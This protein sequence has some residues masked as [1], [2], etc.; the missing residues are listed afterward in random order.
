MLF[1]DEQEI[2]DKEEQT[3]KAELTWLLES[4]LPQ[5]IKEAG[6]LLSECL[7]LSNA[8]DQGIFALSSTNCD[9]L[10]GYVT[11][12]DC[13]IVKGD[14]QIKLPSYHRGQ[15]FRTAIASSKPYFLEQMQ[16]AHNFVELAM[17]DLKHSAVPNTLLAARKRLSLLSDHTERAIHSLRHISEGRTFPNKLCDPRH[18]SPELPEELVIEF[19]VHDVY[20]IVMA[21][22]LEYHA[23]PPQ[24]RY[25]FLGGTS[26]MASKVHKY[27]DKSVTVLD[28]VVVHTQ[29]PT[30]E[31]IMARLRR[32]ATL[33][34]EFELKL[35]LFH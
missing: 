31:N 17:A 21:C 14:L 15:L 27:R 13:Q 12:S 6:Q 1:E 28:E 30:L 25:G 34:R 19:Y 2:R 8:A 29:V 22:V 24:Q 16:D 7:E 35:S 10:K 26:K 32:V 3:L 9:A 4:Q 23:Q 11:M 5:V 20:L 33:C 18:F